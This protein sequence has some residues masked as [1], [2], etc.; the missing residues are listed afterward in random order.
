MVGGVPRNPPPGNPVRTYPSPNI[1]D[2]V[3]VE[4]VTSELANSNPIDPGTPHPNQR[5]FPGYKLGIQKVN[6]ADHNFFMRMWVTDE[7]SP[8][9][10]NFALKYVAES[11]AHPIFIRSYREPKATYSARTRGTPLQTVYKLAVTAAGSGYTPGTS[12]ALTFSGGGGGAGAAGHAVVSPTGTITEFVLTNGGH[13]Y[14]GAPTFTVA[15]PPAGGTTATGTAFIQP[16][17][18]ILISEEPQQFPQD[19]E[20]YALYLNVVRVYKTTPGPPLTLKSIGIQDPIPSIFKSTTTRTETT[21]DVAPTTDPGA[22]TGN[23]I[24]K[25]VKQTSATE[26]VLTTIE[27]DIDFEVVVEDFEV[28]P[29]TGIVVHIS[30]QLIKTADFDESDAG[31][32]PDGS[33][34]EFQG[35]GA[36]LAIKLTS[37]VDEATLPDDVSTGTI[38]D[39]SLPDVMTSIPVLVPG[40]SAS[41]GTGSDFGAGYSWDA[42]WKLSIA[43][44]YR[45][46]VKGTTV[47]SYSATPP[48]ESDLPSVT[49]LKTKTGTLIVFY[50]DAQFT[51]TGSST[52]ITHSGHAKVTYTQNILCAGFAATGTYGTNPYG[53]AGNWEI[54]IPATSPASIPST[55]VIRARVTKFR[56]NVYITDVTTVTTP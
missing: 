22:L 19:S 49:A 55:M 25:E 47:R 33:Y 52:R 56:F 42:E 24:Y 32:Q 54:D 46:P 7:T 9:A 50:G 51:A 13:D 39:I 37:T 1:S 28:D 12:P 29:E 23:Q 2:Q 34:V 16:T 10:W 5:D 20:F 17:G 53:D 14:T 43:N 21:Q 26:A 15:A 11:A 4:F 44:G 36:G 27:Q 30:K 18:A 31:V 8:D 3:V 45:G 38:E 40:S 48:A 6:P 41:I 35:I